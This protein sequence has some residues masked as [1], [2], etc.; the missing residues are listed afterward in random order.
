MPDLYAVAGTPTLC[1]P[2]HPL[3]CY[4][5]LPYSNRNGLH[6]SNS[7]FSLLPFYAFSYRQVADEVAECQRIL[8]RSGLKYKVRMYVIS[9]LFAH[10]LTL[11][12]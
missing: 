4:R 12:P 10:P 5:F 6:I 8:A 2:I 7:P 1:P 11:C 9:R 3:T